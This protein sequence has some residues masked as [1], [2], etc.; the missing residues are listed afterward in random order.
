MS[1]TLQG[2]TFHLEHITP[3]TCGGLSSLE[4]LALACVSCNLHK[5]DRSHGQDPESGE[6][7]PLFH[8]RMHRWS[9]HFAWIGT[10]LT[11]MTPIGRGT[12][13]ALDLNHPRRVLVREA[14]SMF[15]LFPPG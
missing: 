15:G 1:Q 3:V 14:E 2:A 8:P 6:S 13:Q 5:S 9:E 4:N 7:V 10:S 11:G 12:I